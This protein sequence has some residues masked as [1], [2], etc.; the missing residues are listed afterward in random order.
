MLR[1]SKLLKPLRPRLRLGRPLLR[2]RQLRRS[3]LRTPP[4]RVFRTRRAQLTQL[5]RRRRTRKPIRTKATEQA[6]GSK[7]AYDK[8]I[9]IKDEIDK[10]N[11]G[12]DEGKPSEGKPGE[13]KPDVAKPTDVKGNASDSATQGIPQPSADKIPVKM[14]KGI[15]ESQES[16][17]ADAQKPGKADAK[18]SK[19]SGKK[20]VKANKEL[21][22]TGVSTTLATIVSSVMALLGIG[23]VTV[24]SKRR[25]ND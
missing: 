3:P 22:K 4:R 1:P 5:R 11:K 9:Q 7:S 18:T 21:G 23:G 19:K 16:G 8:L 15:Q 14:T 12:K 2:L 6:K 17:K 20:V 24:A 25:E 10:A 13:G